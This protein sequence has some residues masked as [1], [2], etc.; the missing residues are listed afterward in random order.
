MFIFLFFLGKLENTFEN[1]Y[2]FLNRCISF[3]L[4]KFKINITLI[5]GAILGFKKMEAVWLAEK[6]FFISLGIKMSV[7]LFKVFFK[8]E[9]PVKI[10]LLVEIEGTRFASLFFCVSM[11]LYFKIFINFFVEKRDTTEYSIYNLL[12]KFFTCFQYYYL[13]CSIF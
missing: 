4:E 13:I 8:S 5:P 6:L 2:K 10:L 12:I 11:F 9:I 1:K 7:S 3:F